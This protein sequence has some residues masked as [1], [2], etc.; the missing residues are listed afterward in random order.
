MPAGTTPKPELQVQL[1][2]RFTRLLPLRRRPL[3]QR[4]RSFADHVP[5]APKAQVQV[6]LIKTG[7]AE[8][9]ELSWTHAVRVPTSPTLRVQPSR[10]GRSRR[11]R[12]VHAEA[13]AGTD[14]NRDR[15]RRQLCYWRIRPQQVAVLA[16]AL[17]VPGHRGYVGWR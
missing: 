4:A 2:F 9:A 8:Q 5:V 6:V 17:D 14:R 12:V 10:P 11:T 1:P 7:V 15:N 13:A 16:I 3:G